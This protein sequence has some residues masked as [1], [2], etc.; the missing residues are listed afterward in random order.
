MGTNF[1]FMTGPNPNEW[2][3][4]GKRSFA[5]WY[6]WDCHTLLKGLLK[7][8]SCGRLNDDNESVR[9]ACWFDWAIK[10]QNGW[11]KVAPTEDKV[12]VG[13]GT[14]YTAVEFFDMLSRMCPPELWNERSVRKEFS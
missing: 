7:C 10:P 4:V 3:H 6:C 11:E 9:P 1:Y 8:P 14:T 2:K 12:I 13:E 5:G